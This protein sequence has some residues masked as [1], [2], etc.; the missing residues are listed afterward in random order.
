MPSIPSLHAQWP[1]Q[2]GAG[3]GNT[4]AP[5]SLNP[6]GGHLRPKGQRCFPYDPIPLMQR[7]RFPT[8]TIVLPCQRKNAGSLSCIPVSLPSLT[9]AKRSRQTPKG[10]GIFGCVARLFYCL[11]TTARR[12]TDSWDG[13]AGQR[14]RDKQGF[15]TQRTRPELPVAI[16][17][18]SQGPSKNTDTYSAAVKQKTG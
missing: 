13:H 7:I 3:A 17:S 12:S 10:F 9:C 14:R 5:R 11:D 15:H 1:A 4:C 2:D 18:K 8:Y 6:M 16:G